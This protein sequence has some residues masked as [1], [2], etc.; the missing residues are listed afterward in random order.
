MIFIFDFFNFCIILPACAF[1][2]GSNFQNLK[3]VPHNHANYSL[4]NCK[5]FVLKFR[6][7]RADEMEVIH[8]FIFLFIV[9]SFP[10]TFFVPQ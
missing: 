9:L 6:N 3:T 8:D 5:K 10:A 7:V 2:F 4:N 1:I